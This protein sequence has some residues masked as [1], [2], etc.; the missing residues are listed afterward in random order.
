L[1]SEDCPQGD[2]DSVLSMTTR[3]GPFVAL[4][5]A[6]AFSALAIP[7]AAFASTSDPS[8]V[9]SAAKSAIA[10]QTGVHLVVAS[11]SSST[12]DT[13]IGDLGVNVGEETI[14]TGSATATIKVT[15]TYSYLSGN[16]AG[17]TSIIGL[18]SAQAKKLGQKWMSV[19]AGTTQY[20][21]L[22]SGSTIA[23]VTAVLP[24]AK[25]TSV[26][27]TSTDGVNVFLLK[28]TTAA[29]SSTPKLENTV[30]I[31]AKGLALPV[32]ETASS[33]SGSG[34]T[35]FSHWGEHVT[36]VAPPTSSTI[37]YTSVVG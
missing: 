36:V 19:K 29:T 34:T 3:P 20:S 27:T 10:K 30:S 5:A 8:S 16:S 28:W 35:K 31:A 23:A 1:L 11:S 37:S 12:K 15:S 14:T 24:P 2:T 33:S 25:G 22:K 32:E 17:L 21:T 4:L 13:V 7:G 9:L 18:S 26:S 6:S